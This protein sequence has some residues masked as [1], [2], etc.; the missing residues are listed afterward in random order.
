MGF[1]QRQARFLT[2]VALHSGYCLRR[3]YAAFAAV[4]YGKNVRDFLDDLVAQQAARRL[5]FRRDRGHIYHLF[6]RSLY[7]AIQQQDN[8]NRRHAS[9]ALIARKLMLLDFVLLHPEREWYVTETEK[10]ELFTRTLRVPAWALPHRTYEATSRTTGPTVRY[11]VQK[12]PIFVTRN[13]LRIHFVCLVTDLA[14]RDISLF[15]REHAALTAQL[16]AHT[17]VV[18]RP[19]HISTD[20]QCRAVHAQAIGSVAAP[21]ESLDPTAVT[22]FFEARRRIERGEIHA[23]SVED[24]QRYRECR[25]RVGGTFEGAYCN[26]V[27]HGYPPFTNVRDLVGANPQTP[28][29]DLVIVQLGHRYEQFGAMPGIV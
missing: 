29:S 12:L 27:D 15:V 18:V 21:G 16:A 7:R 23:L 11:H 10:V 22:W 6:S 20:A 19:S 1:T 17:L 13:P 26:W 14:A 3:Q 4:S 25:R 2:L 9:P 24:I 8:R 28:H 5:T